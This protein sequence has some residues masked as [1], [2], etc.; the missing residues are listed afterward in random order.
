M[1]TW[2]HPNIEIFSENGYQIATLPPDGS[3]LMTSP[4]R[5]PDKKYRWTFEAKAEQTG[6]QI[7]TGI[8]GGPGSR[9]INLTTNWKQYSSVGTPD[10]RYL[11]L[12]LEFF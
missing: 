4:S 9:N 1:T 8:W 5:E 11:F 10:K 3:Q 7:F 6:D 12:L 2:E